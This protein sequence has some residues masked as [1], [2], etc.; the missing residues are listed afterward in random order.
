MADYIITF[1]KQ[2]ILRY[3]SHLDMVR[4]FK[5]LFNRANIKLE[6]S[7][8]FNPH[9][10]MTFAQPLSL[11]YTSKGEVLEIETKE[12]IAPTEIMER[13]N[14]TLPEGL[15]ILSC[16]YASG[17]KMSFAKNISYAHY[18]VNIENIINISNENVEEFLQQESIIVQKKKKKSSEMKDVDI[19]PLIRKIETTVVDNNM[20][21][22]LILDAGS[23]SNLSPDLF[24]TAFFTYFNIEKSEQS[25]KIE[26][27]EIN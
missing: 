11:G 26:R 16:E 9:P 4:F 23:T 8:G 15:K 12:D 5:R 2:G 20:F 3:T 17:K 24:L 10:K 27:L 22:S 7:R 6:Y 25:F 1:S 19:K 14:N 13:M 21:L 18:L